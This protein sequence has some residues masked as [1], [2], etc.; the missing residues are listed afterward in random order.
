MEGE[1][2]PKKEADHFR[3]VG[4]RFNKQGNLSMWLV[5]GPKLT[6]SLYLPTIILKDYI[7]VLAGC[8]HMFSPD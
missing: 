6:R 1:K 7:D 2:R 4:D 8:S 5:F 3:S